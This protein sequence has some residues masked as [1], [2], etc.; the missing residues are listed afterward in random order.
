MAA[1]VEKLAT[2]W[3][4]VTLTGPRQSGKTTLCRALFPGHSYISF[5]APD[6]RD[7]AQTDPRGLL[8]EYGAGAIFDEIQRVPELLSYLQGEVDENPRPGRFILTG[9]AHFSLLEG[10]TQSLAG[11]TALGHLL[12]LSLPEIRHSPRSS[13]SLAE[14]PT[15]AS[16]RK[17]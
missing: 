12:P 11:R 6:N 15:G 17:S 14:P 1:H 13:R 16:S 8:R 4:A 9:S 7:Y 2:R 3:P 5:E 10:V